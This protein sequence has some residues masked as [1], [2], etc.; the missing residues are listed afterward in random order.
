[1]PRERSLGRELL[2]G[3]EPAIPYVRAYAAVEKFVLWLPPTLG[4]V[5]GKQRTSEPIQ[6]NE[7]NTCTNKLNINL[8]SQTDLDINI[9]NDED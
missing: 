9:E 4:H 7:Q 5:V 1:V 6:S 2:T 3:F 8:N